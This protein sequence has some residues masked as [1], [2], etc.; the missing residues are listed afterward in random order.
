MDYASSMAKL[1]NLLL[2]VA[3]TTVLG[4]SS[5]FADD[6]TVLKLLTDNH[7]NENDVL[8]IEV[9]SDTVL[10]KQGHAIGGPSLFVVHSDGSSQEIDAPQPYLDQAKELRLMVV[11]AKVP[12]ASLEPILAN[13]RG[14]ADEVRASHLK[15]FLQNPTGKRS[16]NSI[17]TSTYWQRK[18]RPVKTVLF[19]FANY[20]G[21]GLA[22]GLTDMLVL[23]HRSDA[24]WKGAAVLYVGAI[25]SLAAGYILSLPSINNLRRGAKIEVQPVSKRS[26]RIAIVAGAT[27]VA[28]MG[29]ALYLREIAKFFL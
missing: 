4:A 18:T 9:N 28:A 10:L 12:N 17:Q 14:S 15:T 2:L 29:C 27:G 6:K 5:L 20:M 25:S 7:L 3:I 22:I 26:R 11:K 16:W 19:S 23:Q 21:A 24:G 13:L 8:L 1:L